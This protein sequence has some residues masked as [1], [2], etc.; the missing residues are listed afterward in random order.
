MSDVK[1]IADRFEIEALR[2]EFTDAAMMHDY[3][4]G[5]TAIN[6]AFGSL[7][8]G[9]GGKPTPLYMAR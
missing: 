7:G 6:P 5:G 8:D 2:D 1:A 4:R 9:G 3:D